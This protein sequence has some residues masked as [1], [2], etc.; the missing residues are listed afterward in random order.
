ML[1]CV[2]IISPF[3]YV[4]YRFRLS[5]VITQC[6]SFTTTIWYD[7]CTWYT[8]VALL[9]IFYLLLLLYDDIF[10]W[11]IKK[12]AYTT[13]YLSSPVV[14]RFCTKVPSTIDT[15][16]TYL[17]QLT[18]IILLSWYF[19]YIFFVS[20]SF[21]ERRLYRQFIWKVDSVRFDIWPR[22]D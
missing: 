16:T 3:L 1:L 8:F 6:S 4:H 21:L 5:I 14:W 20:H 10:H 22:E 7:V 2:Y 17:I 13:Q 12:D 15:D 11:C 9:F 19:L 18:E